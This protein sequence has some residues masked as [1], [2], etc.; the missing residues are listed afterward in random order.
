MGA[1]D[2]HP[3]PVAEVDAFRVV[4][5]VSWNFCRTRVNTLGGEAQKVLPTGQR[6]VILRLLS[7]FSSVSLP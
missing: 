5:R 3:R 7:G 1:P 4:V 6:G 2:P